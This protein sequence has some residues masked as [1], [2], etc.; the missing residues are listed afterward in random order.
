[1]LMESGRVGY[2][3]DNS[4]FLTGFVY[5]DEWGR[6]AKIKNSWHKYELNKKLI[7]KIEN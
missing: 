6:P 1:M 5:E 4:F 2:L 7:R 3:V